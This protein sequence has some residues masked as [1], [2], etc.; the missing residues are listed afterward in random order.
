MN[1]T[2]DHDLVNDQPS[3]NADEDALLQRV[4]TDSDRLLTQSLREDERRRRARRVLFLTLLL[5]GI[6]M[7]TTVV[8]VLAG[9]LTLFTPQPDSS[10]A[11]S[12]RR[13]PLSDDARIEMAEELA[14]EGWQLWQQR[15]LGEAAAKFERAVKLDPEAAN[16]W[17]GLGWAQFNG[18]DSEAAVK[19]FEKCVE[20]E[21]E[22][23]A[24]LN[25]LGQIYLS[26]REYDKA[27]KYLTKAAPTAP[28]AWF[29]LSRLYM[30]TGK[31]DE[32]QK[33]IEKALS[34]QPA[35]E[36]LQK[37]QAA[38]KQGQLPDDLR[39]LIEPAGKPDNTPAAKAANAGWQQF[40]QGNFR[41]AERHFRRAL[42]KDPDNLAAMNGLGFILL[43]T[44]KTA[45]AK[46]YF[47][48]YLK[49]EPDA[50]GPMNGLARCLKA[51][52][53]VDEAIAL[54][55]KMYKMYPGPNA[56]AV[57][58]AQTYVERGEHAKAIPYFEELVKAQ[59]D[60]AE[61]KQGLEAAR[62]GAK[63]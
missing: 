36:S 44:G 47:E 15:K 38:A 27:E 9:W 39:R 23:P 60:N 2:T 32:A 40:N 50:A 46:E 21:P 58:L 16:A 20:L 49:L 31:Y 34:Q 10:G 61:F 43:N 7:G 45:S 42:A 5:G 55:E 26:W 53:K 14:G 13:E 41:S 56:A 28:A 33:W 59:P 4:L 57:G 35:D 19:A 54:W 29:G 11:E 63:K 18:G 24:G 3:A 25:G 1:P 48:K 51:E 17:N 6:G 8:A 22:H 52:G 30:L 12:T 62:E 37:L